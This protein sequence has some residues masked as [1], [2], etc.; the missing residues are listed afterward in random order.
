MHYSLGVA[1]ARL[2]RKPAAMQAFA[3]AVRLKPGYGEALGEIER[4]RAAP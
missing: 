4:L 3:E 2:G 1:L